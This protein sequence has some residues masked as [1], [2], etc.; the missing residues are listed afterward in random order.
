[1]VQVYS[2]ARLDLK[3]KSSRLV[4]RRPL[5]QNL[6]RNGTIHREMPRPIHRAHPALAKTFLDAV[7]FVERTPDER[8]RCG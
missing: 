8:I 1:M 4:F 2:R 3:T 7:L 6:D 5:M